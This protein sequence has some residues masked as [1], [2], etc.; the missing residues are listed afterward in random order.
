MSH[1][2]ENNVIIHKL[3]QLMTELISGDY[4]TMERKGTLRKNTAE[5]TA[6]K[7]ALYPGKLMMP[8]RSCF[9]N[10]VAMWETETEGD[11]IRAS[12]I[13][14][15]LWF[16]GQAGDLVLEARCSESHDGEITVT[17]HDIL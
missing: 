7:I 17:V 12:I 6:E 5:G 2:L 10:P 13:V 11:E 3:M 9:E 1:F 14:V 8:P 4:T 16:S 15:N